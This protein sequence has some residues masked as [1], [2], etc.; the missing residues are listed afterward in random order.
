MADF[1]H[2]Y[3]RRINKKENAGKILRKGEDPSKTTKI[4][5][6]KGEVMT[7]K[8]KRALQRVFAMAL[9]AALL[10]GIPCFRVEAAES[11]AGEGKP[12]ELEWIPDEA[13][14]EDGP[15][16]YTLLS[17]CTV[18][19]ASLSEGLY[20]HVGTCTSQPASVVGVRDIVL[21]RKTLL[22]W[23]GVATCAGGEA[24]DTAYYG[25]G[26]TY[27]NAEYNKKY[28]VTCTHYGTVDS[29]AEV[30]H[31]TGTYTYNYKK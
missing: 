25:G 7:Y 27:K 10:M 22:G 11:G 19:F 3:N 21:E 4:K 31:E 9:T 18:E 6:R 2:V 23:H 30:Y 1:C 24:Y 28:R 29:P 12:V 15:V 5:K 17:D 14:G 20:V 16:C 13:M 8:R 26:F